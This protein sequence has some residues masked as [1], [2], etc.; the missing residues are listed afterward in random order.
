MDLPDLQR[1]VITILHVDDDDDIRSIAAMALGL[2]SWPRLFQ[3]ASGQEAI[4]AVESIKPDVLLLDVMMPGLSG[5]DTWQIIQQ[6]PKMRAIPTI[7]MTARAENSYGLKLVDMGA[8][9]VI[10]KPFDPLT[11]ADQIVTLLKAT[12]AVGNS[13][14]H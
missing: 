12:D 2:A 6:L 13:S 5:E 11:L 4:E 7:F 9:G 3:F 1:G 8:I 14:I 10:T